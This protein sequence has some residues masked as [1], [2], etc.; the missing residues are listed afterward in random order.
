[1]AEDGTS[2]SG[3]FRGFHKN[4]NQW[5]LYASEL[6]FREDFRNWPFKPLPP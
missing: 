1:M 5:V 2:R 3:K 6:P 4:L